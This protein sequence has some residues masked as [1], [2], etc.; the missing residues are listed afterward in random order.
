MLVNPSFPVG[1]RKQGQCYL[2]RMPTLWMVRAGEGG[3]QAANFERSGYAGIGWDGIG[4]FSSLTTLEAMR[5]A[6][7]SAYPE[8][9]PG[10]LAASASM[11]YKFRN[12]IAPGDRVVSYD[13]ERRE[14]LVG[15][16]TGGYEFRR[17]VLPDY[18]H[19]RKVQWDGRVERDALS[20]AVR[21]T[22]GSV[23]TIFEPGEKALSELTAGMQSRPVASSTAPIESVAEP[24]D[25]F[26]ELRRD[27]LSKAHEFIKDR[28]LSLSPD[29]MELLVANLLR[30]LGYKARVTPKGPDRG[31]DVIASPDGLGFQ[32]PRIVAEVKHRPR[33]AMGSE[34]I[35]SFLG[36]LRG[37]D[38][39]LY[40]STG[41]FTREA[42]YEADRASIPVTL[43]NLDDLASSIVEHYDTFEPDGRS[44]L[45]LVKVYFPA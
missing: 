12:I 23:L 1:R 19:L 28:I 9:K 38:R 17:G 35:R 5:D 45:P 11:A 41:G 15:T 31:R 40:V 21:N 14:Y 22:L 29:D 36:G 43:M 25:D 16:V 3:Y 24:A 26:E 42:S 10:W 34:K 13:P 37:S 7:R 30:A 27:V 39:G 32:Q 44:L 8:A 4:D 6:L 20:T 18:N 2:T 33:E